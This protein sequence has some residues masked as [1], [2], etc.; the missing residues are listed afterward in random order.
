MCVKLSQTIDDEYLS[1]RV[2]R[3]LP[4]DEKHLIIKFK[5]FINKDSDDPEQSHDSSDDE[6]SNIKDIG[7]RVGDENINILGCFA[8]EKPIARNCNQKVEYPNGPKV[9]QIVKEI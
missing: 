8:E 6:K 2:I 9:H 1:P 4:V 5:L 7:A 3:F